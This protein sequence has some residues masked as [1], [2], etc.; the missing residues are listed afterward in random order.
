MKKQEI[1]EEVLLNKNL[2]ALQ[3]IQNPGERGGI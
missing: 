2:R 3:M 1:F